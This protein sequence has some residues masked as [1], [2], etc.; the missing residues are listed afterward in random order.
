[1]NFTVLS[2]GDSP[3][4]KSVSDMTCGNFGGNRT[5][6][7]SFKDH[8]YLKRAGGAPNVK[9]NPVDTA[10]RDIDNMDNEQIGKRHH[11]RLE[12]TSNRQ[13]GN[14]ASFMVISCSDN[15]ARKDVSDDNIVLP[16]N[17]Q[18]KRHRKPNPWHLGT[19]S[20]YDGEIS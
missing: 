1:M 3:T 6:G 2:P 10:T 5:V 15:Q 9:K 16:N 11:S 20:V 18:P 7:S 4:K 12:E 17:L 14:E 13:K 19:E 8:D